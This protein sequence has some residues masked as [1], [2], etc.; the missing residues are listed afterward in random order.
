[1]SKSQLSLGS[2]NLDIFSKTLIDL[3]EK[4]QDILV[5]TSDSR[6]SGKLTPFGKKFPNQMIEIGIAEQNLVGISAGLAASGKKVFAIS[7]ACFLTARALEQIKNDIAYSNRPVKI[8]G[9][10]AGVSYGSLGSTHH[11]LHDFA[12][13]QAIHNI[14]IVAPADNFET[15][16]AIR[17]SVDHPRPIYI[18][19]GKKPLLNLHENGTH[20]EIGKAILLTP[21]REQYDVAFIAT[22]ETVAQAYF[23]S[24]GLSELG[25]TSCVLSF[26]SIRPFDKE[27]VEQAASRSKVVITVEEH[28]INGGLGCHIA[29]FLMEA[30][31]F[32]PLKIA[33]IPD[34]HT[35][36]GNQLEIF[37]H[38][39]ITQEGLMESAQ[40][41]LE[42]GP[43]T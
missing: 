4:D 30:G 10:S 21:K 7:P 31:I 43:D 42:K 29:S 25:I 27:A 3:A 1:M 2:A 18:R 11:S 28:S 36:T 37:R 24:V 14:D 5:V 38:Y 22:G 16:A 12:V 33:G 23:A 13:L 41:L 8:I 35:I 26:H 34:E 40:N 17:A 9:I 15:I 19:F 32:R 6:A 39:G 20:F